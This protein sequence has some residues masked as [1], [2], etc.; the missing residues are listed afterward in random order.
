MDR[1]D[2]QDHRKPSSLEL[3]WIMGF[4]TS[5]RSSRIWKVRWKRGKW[6][7]YQLQAKSYIRFLTHITSFNLQWSYF[8]DERSK[9]LKSWMMSLKLYCRY[10]MV[11]LETLE[12]HC[13][14]NLNLGGVWK[15]SC[16]EI[17]LFFSPKDQELD[18]YGVRIRNFTHIILHHCK[19]HQ[20][21]LEKGNQMWEDLKMESS[22]SILLEN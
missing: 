20:W 17:R 7:G 19:C 16:K 3:C 9:G 14:R 21:K 10:A 5:H 12:V 4:M 15:K 22:D 13:G 6:T 8:T 11:P 2:C 1:Y 18:R